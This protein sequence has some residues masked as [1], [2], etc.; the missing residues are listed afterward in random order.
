MLQ[1]TRI[2][3]IF[4]IIVAIYAV[5]QVWSWKK[6]NS[7][8]WSSLASHSVAPTVKNKEQF[9][10]LRVPD[11]SNAESSMPI[12]NEAVEIEKEK[13]GANSNRTETQTAT[14]PDAVEII[15][16]TAKDNVDKPEEIKNPPMSGNTNN[17]G[18]KRY[19]RVA[20][21]TKIHGPHQWI[22]VEQSMCLLH[23]AYNH[24]VLYDIV[25]FTATEVPKE[26]IDDFEKMVA[27]ANVSVVMDNIG[28]QEEIAAL[29]PAKHKLFLE[30]C[31]VTDPVNLTWWSNCREPGAKSVRKQKSG[32]G[33]RVAYNWQAEFRSVRIWEDPALEK[34][35]YMIWLGSDGFPSKPMGEGSRGVFY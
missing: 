3:L 33:G 9:K 2:R 19:D 29:T 35:R 31:M 6:F 11:N 26:L 21:V 16:K 10:S 1:K 14:V 5:I 18:F 25:I 34:Y 27:P 7:Q 30:R 20:I 12:G 8:E 23:H 4:V 32:S 28:F 15:K 24:K 22:Q 17:T 13:G